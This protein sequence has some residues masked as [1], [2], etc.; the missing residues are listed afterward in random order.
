MPGIDVRI[1]A[2]PC[3]GIQECRD[4][5]DEIYCQDDKA[6]LVIVLSVLIL[7][8]VC[9]YLYLIWM[10]IPDSVHDFQ[11]VEVGEWNEINCINLKGDDLVKL[12]V[13]HFM[14]IIIF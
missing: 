2:I 11:S 12:K 14:N 10:K 6:I 13:I 3:D 9:F 8:T 7:V 1:M 5:R 4:G